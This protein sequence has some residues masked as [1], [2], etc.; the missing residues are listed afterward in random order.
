MR[1]AADFFSGTEELAWGHW[2]LNKDLVDSKSNRLLTAT[3][4]TNYTFE[5]SHL[6][7]SNVSQAVR[8]GFNTGLRNVGTTGFTVCVVAKQSGVATSFAAIAGN[9]QDNATGS[10]LVYSGKVAGYATGLGFA[11]APEAQTD[12]TKW[13]FAAASYSN[14]ENVVRRM[15]V[16]SGSYSF[17]NE[18]T[19]T[20][21]I[22]DPASANV[23]NSVCL[24]A[25]QVS[26]ATDSFSLDFAEFIVFNSALSIADMKAIAFRSKQR[27]KTKGITI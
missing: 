20:G 7:L 15:V 17:T 12:T 13:F 27:M 5:N 6:K 22:V 25:T 10:L 16:E 26:S 8:K 11:D 14:D 19:G 9:Q 2:T 1:E 4:S 24:G 21:R 3:A 18:F 23:F